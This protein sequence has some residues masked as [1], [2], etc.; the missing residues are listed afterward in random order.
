MPEPTGYGS[1]AVDE[2]VDFTDPELIAEIR[3]TVDDSRTGDFLHAAH[4]EPANYVRE[5]AGHL[6]HSPGDPVDQALREQAAVYA[7]RLQYPPVPTDDCAWRESMPREH[8]NW[9]TLFNAASTPRGAG[10]Q[11]R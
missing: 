6:D 5:I 2:P 4:E 11:T 1:A 9:D 7:G 8:D 10:M 3:Q